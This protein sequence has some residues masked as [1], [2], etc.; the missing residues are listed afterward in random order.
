MSKLG[1]EQKVSLMAHRVGLKAAELA[2]AEA[3]P[4]ASRD[5]ATQACALIYGVLLIQKVSKQR[6]LMHL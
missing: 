1:L 4:W 5:P 3:V 2:A 6:V